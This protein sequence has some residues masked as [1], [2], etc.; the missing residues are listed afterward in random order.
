MDEVVPGN[1]ISDT[2]CE[3]QYIGDCDHYCGNIDEVA[4]SITDMNKPTTVVVKYCNI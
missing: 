2:L 1:K 4:V 3:E